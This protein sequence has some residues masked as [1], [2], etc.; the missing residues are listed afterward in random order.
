M[1]WPRVEDVINYI[2]VLFVGVVDLDGFGRSI[3]VDSFLLDF[4]ERTVVVASVCV[5][6]SGVAAEKTSVRVENRGA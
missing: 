4:G 1:R 5:D 3:V 6:E 2:W